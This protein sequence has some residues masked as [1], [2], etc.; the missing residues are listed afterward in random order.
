MNSDSPLDSS[1]LTS[2]RETHTHT[3]PSLCVCVTNRDS[4]RRRETEGKTSSADRQVVSRGLPLHTPLHPPL[5]ISLL[6]VILLRSNILSLSS[7]L[8]CVH[9]WLHVKCRV[10]SR[11]TDPLWRARGC[12]TGKVMSPSLAPALCHVPPLSRSCLHQ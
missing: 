5:P 2:E 8:A 3:S 7:L 4:E 9:W 10:Q 11:L 6:S 12:K 1:L